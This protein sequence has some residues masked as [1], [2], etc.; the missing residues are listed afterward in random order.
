[1]VRGCVVH[2]VG[3]VTGVCKEQVL[4]PE[5]DQTNLAI[6]AMARIQGSTYNLLATAHASGS[7]LIYDLNDKHNI[8]TVQHMSL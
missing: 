6:M 7:I 4:G 2:R 5:G 1:M 3:F 8:L